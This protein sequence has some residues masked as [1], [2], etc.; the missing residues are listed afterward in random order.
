MTDGT[1]A[2]HK[3]K[4]RDKVSEG[5]MLAEIETDKS[6]KNLSLQRRNPLYIGIQEGE[7]APVDSLLATIGKRR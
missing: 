6:N 1:V 4:S 2:T 5:D 3:K 7:T